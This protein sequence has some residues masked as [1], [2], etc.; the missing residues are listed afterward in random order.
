MSLSV[1]DKNSLFRKM[2]VARNSNETAVKKVV[3]NKGNKYVFKVWEPSGRKLSKKKLDRVNKRGLQMSEGEGRRWGVPTYFG[4]KGDRGCDAVTVNTDVVVSAGT[5]G[6][7][8][9]GGIAVKVRVLGD[10]VEKVLVD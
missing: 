2:K 8:E 9:V 6:S 1:D 4:T 10:G 7:N 3:R 5:E